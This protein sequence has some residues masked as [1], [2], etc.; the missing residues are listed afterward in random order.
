MYI[1]C[2]LL[3]EC[4]DG[5]RPRCKSCTRCGEEKAR[6]RAHRKLILLSYRCVMRTMKVALMIEPNKLPHQY[7][8]QIGNQA[9]SR[10]LSHHFSHICR[11]F[12]CLHLLVV[13]AEWTRSLLIL[14]MSSYFIR[15]N[16]Y[17]LRTESGYTCRW[18]RLLFQMSPFQSMW[19]RNGSDSLLGH[20][21]DSTA[22]D[23]P[24]LINCF[25]NNFG[26]M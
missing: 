9:N 24:H 4:A 12:V 19:N 8:T 3:L 5:G 23:T 26:C 14:H 16:Y 13:S 7:E 10:C 25:H 18:K 22:K 15:D 1:L 6:A 11:L 17:V 2:L 20:L 21:S